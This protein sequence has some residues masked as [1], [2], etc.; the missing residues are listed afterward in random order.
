M[1]NQTDP[2]STW[3]TDAGDTGTPWS[4][5]AAHELPDTRNVP[6]AP[7]PS[8]II[9]DHQNVLTAARI[10]QDQVDELRARF[11]AIRHELYVEPPGADVVSTEAAGA[12]NHRLTVAEDSYAA[13][14][15]QY[16]H[17]LDGVAHALRHSAEQYGFTE[18]EIVAA[19]GKQ[20]A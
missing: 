12:W 5:G 6:A 10:I 4:T 19:L 3:F 18:E 14:V 11:A 20:R 9:V 13:R 17:S 16:I 2:A 15:A 7:D 8:R 1:V